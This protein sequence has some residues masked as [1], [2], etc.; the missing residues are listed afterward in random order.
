[1]RASSA[2]RETAGRTA[3]QLV[4]SL[5]RTLT[6]TLSRR[7]GRGDKRVPGQGDMRV[8]ADARRGYVAGVG[9]GGDVYHWTPCPLRPL[10]LGC[11]RPMLSTMVPDA[12]TSDAVALH[13]S[14]HAAEPRRGL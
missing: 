7:T 10:A 3:R 14:P 13:D 11:P 12:M 5:Q 9:K 6:L 2:P 8:H 1:M 4:R